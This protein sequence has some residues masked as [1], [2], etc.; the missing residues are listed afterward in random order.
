MMTIKRLNNHRYAQCHVRVHDN[1]DI[2]FVSYN[3]T[4]I[5][6]VKVGHKYNVVCT[7]TYSATTRKQIGWFLR[8][9]LPM[10][11]YYDMKS[12][13]GTGEYVETF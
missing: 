13:A 6:A 11:N 3:T 5:Y 2:E 4:V 8:E 9:Y 10:L 1:G 12:I 7:G